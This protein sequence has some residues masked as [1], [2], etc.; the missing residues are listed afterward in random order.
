MKPFIRITEAWVPSGDGHVLEPAGGLFGEAT[1]F[2]MITR[3]LSFRRGEGL[4]GQAWAEGR[5]V[6]LKDF[7]QLPFQRGDAAKALG[8]SCAVAL[9]V[10]VH[11]RLT[12]VLVLFCGDEAAADTEAGALELWHND[13]RLTTDMT[14]VDGYYGGTPGAFE[15]LSRDTFLPRGSGLPGLA[16]QREAAVFMQDLGSAPRFLRGETA[17]QAGIRRG[18]ALPCSAQ[19]RQTYV[20]ALLSAASRPMARRM[21]SWLPSATTPGQL[22]RGFGFCEAL[23]P[24]PPDDLITSADSLV[25]RSFA[26]GVPMLS[27]RAGAEPDPLGAS[28]RAGGI[29]SMVTIPLT[30]D[31]QVS[32]VVVL[33][34]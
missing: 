4:P 24:L 8:L 2:G 28:A 5:P 20:L 34:F 1:N 13:P 3:D 22:T 10:F 32:E 15:S 6:L 17:V 11:D 19:T 12:G 26:S 21:E 16:W 18:L 25:M 29:G 7:D 9:P 23:G 30:A 14:L 27:D 33:Y 31:G